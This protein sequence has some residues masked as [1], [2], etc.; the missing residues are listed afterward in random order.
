MANKKKKTPNKSNFK[1]ASPTVAT[2]LIMFGVIFEWGLPIFIGL[3]LGL[4]WMFRISKNNPKLRFL[5]W[6]LISALVILEI[7]ATVVDLHQ[8]F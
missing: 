2:V 8:N 4:I 3:V 6:V 5:W 1:Y 7:Y